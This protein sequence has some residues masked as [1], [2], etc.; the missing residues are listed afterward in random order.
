[1]G[2]R[3]GGGGVESRATTSTSTSTSTSPFPFPCSYPYPFPFPSPSAQPHPHAHTTYTTNP[4]RST[5]NAEVF[6]VFVCP[7]QFHGFCRIFSS[8]QS[9]EFWTGVWSLE[10]KLWR[11]T[12]PSRLALSFGFGEKCFVCKSLKLHIMASLAVSSSWPQTETN[13]LTCTVQPGN[14]GNLVPPMKT[15]NGQW[16]MAR[17]ESNWLRTGH[18]RS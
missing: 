11:S 8:S 12:G 4:H 2:R 6:N 16:R 9:S 3:R 18:D 7:C 5:A 10:L 1:V 14:L 17:L 15:S 13:P